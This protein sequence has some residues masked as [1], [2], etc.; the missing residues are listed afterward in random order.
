MSNLLTII[1][2][3]LLL[4]AVLIIR[5]QL[6]A[7]ECSRHTKLAGFLAWLVAL[8]CFVAGFYLLALK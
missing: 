7:K 4:L 6:K 2:I 3:A 5:A 1:A 8:I